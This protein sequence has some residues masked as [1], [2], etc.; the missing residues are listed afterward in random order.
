M[1]HRWAGIGLW[2]LLLFIPATGWGQE[3]PQTNASTESSFR[4]TSGHSAL[5]ISRSG[6][7]GNRSENQHDKGTAK[8]SGWSSMTGSLVI[9]ITLIIGCGYFLK[10]VRGPDRGVLPDE[11]LQI[12]GRKTLDPRTTLQLVH[13]GSK[14]LI[15][16]NSI[17]HGV[18]TLSEITNPTDVETIL[19]QCQSSFA[20]DIV[21]SPINGLD[22]IDT[23][24]ESRVVGDVIQSPA[25]SRMP[26]HRVPHNE[27]RVTTLGGGPHA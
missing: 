4:D 16:T 10:R 7:A 13:C 21:S 3:F 6:Q 14:I 1:N 27:P 17:Q 18:R 20:A 8:P 11:I 12:L 25:N 19:R 22:N 23:G 2:S 5:K 15:L 9:V 24:R 26:P